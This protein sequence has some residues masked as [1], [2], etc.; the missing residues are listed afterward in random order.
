MPDGIPPSPQV[1]D[2]DILIVGGGF[3][4]CGA[5]FEARYWGRDLKIVLVEKAAIERSGAVAQGLSAIN[6]YMGM[7]WGENRPEDFVRYVRND[8]MG[9]SREDLVY[10]VARH[11]DSSVHLFEEWGLPIFTDPK[12]GRYVR[13]GRWQVMIHG[14]SYKPIIAEAARAA[15]SQVDEHVIITHLL[16]SAADPK[17]IA[18]AVGFSVR[19]GTFRVYR[20]RAVIVAAG[21]AS[22]LFRPRS[23]G[24]GWGRTWYPP[25]STGSAYALLIRAG[26]EMTQ[27]ENRLVVTRFKDGY[28]PVGA[29]FLYLKAIATNAA[30]ESYETTQRAALRERVG[31]Y[32]DATPLPTCLRNDLMFREIQQGRGPIL[33]HT[34][35]AL[36]TP[37]KETVAWE[38]FLNMTVGQA[39]TW[40]AQG[41]DPRTQPVELILSEPYVLGSHAVC[42]GAWT[43]GPADLSPEDYRWGYNRMTT[44]AGLFGAGDTVG[45][46][47]HKFSSGS[48]TEGRLAAKAAIRFATDHPER[49]EPAPAELDRL[50][51]TIFAPLARY[52]ESRPK[53]TSGVVHPDLLFPD[54]ALHRLEK[55]MDEYGGGVSANYATSEP[56][57]ARGLTQLRHLR[58]DLAHL[59]ASDLHQ[60]GRC[61]E[62]D[63]RVLTAEAVLQHT[64]YRTET[65]W[66]GYYYRSDYPKVDDERWR[67]FVNST[68]DAATGTWS[69]FTRPLHALV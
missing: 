10:D 59:G 20:A 53:I 34:E 58:E 66:P 62:L 1:V 52:L 4:G 16:P 29:F 60:L 44:I 55:I 61:W 46:S 41:T 15:A 31:A 67:C 7:R 45:G 32:A 14:E 26:A 33:M 22:H 5:A 49:P 56:L 6:C 25:W 38:A 47:A 36:D 2:C 37:E 63:H 50:R 42:A 18:G 48:F 28:G 12:T 11:V 57:L 65:R 68:Y 21:G 64:R 69:L 35:R 13:E 8:L 27:M 24:E 39:V 40:A 17:R 19:D 3:A 30:G 54:Q 51:A 23:A 9:L 43:S